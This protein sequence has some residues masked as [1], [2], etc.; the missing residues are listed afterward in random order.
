MP[1]LPACSKER[2]KRGVFGGQKTQFGQI[3]TF[4][5]SRTDALLPMRVK[6]GV[7]EQTHRLHFHLNVFIVSASGGQKP[8]FLAN[9]DILGAPAPT[10]VYG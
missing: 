2:S 3:L 8:Q 9:V 5:G 4:G 10:P 7:L 1:A 6:V